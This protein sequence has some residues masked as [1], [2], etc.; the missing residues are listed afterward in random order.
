MVTM[1]YRPIMWHLMKYYAHYGFKDFILCLGYRADYIKNYFLN[2]NECASN[3]F[4]LSEGAKASSCSRA[5]SL[6]GGSRSSTPGVHSNIGKR[7]KAV[8]KHLMGRGVLP[9]QLFRWSQRS[10]LP[11]ATRS[12]FRPAAVAS[13]LSVQ[14]RRSTSHG[15]AER[16]RTC[17]C[18]R[19][20]RTDK[21]A[22]QRRLLR[23]SRRDIP[24]T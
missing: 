22:Y 6:T 5:T 14:A 13:F 1:G 9:G 8:E 21:P 19:G 16:G 2:Y 7:L 24:T 18:D 10:R 12:L 20:H 4:T 11:D 15:D 3:D 17:H 23:V